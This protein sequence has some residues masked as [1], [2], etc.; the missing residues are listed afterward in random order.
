MRK[1]LKFAFLLALISI[2]QSGS[3]RAEFL[4]A[5]YHGSAILSYALNDD[6][7]SITPLPSSPLPITGGSGSLAVDRSNRF[8]YADTGEGISGYRIK[9]NGSL[10]PLK[11][12]PFKVAGGTLAIDPL[13]RYLYAAAGSPFSTQSNTVSAYRID[14][15]GT[16]KPVPGSPFSTGT[17]PISVSVDPFG[18]FVYVANFVSNNVS[19]FRILENGALMQVLGS[20][21]SSGDAI[22]VLTEPSG[23]FVYVANIF[24]ASISAYHVDPS[25]ALIPLAGSP[26]KT[27]VPWIQ[28]MAIDPVDG[29]LYLATGVRSLDAY[30]F[31][32]NTGEPQFVQQTVTDS[33][34]WIMAVDP[35]SKFVYVAD[36]NR[37]PNLGPDA[38]SGF[39]I[40]PGGVLNPVVSSPVLPPVPNGAFPS[41]I[42]IVRRSG[43]DA[44]K[45]GDPED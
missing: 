20:P 22:T 1:T 34:P 18:R 15:N 29:F 11:G 3:L 2:A 17:Y 26:T 41:S 16:L 35:L 19:V 31:D 37:E 5:S 21:F 4:Y 33:E 9:A 24:E 42:V 45:I 28:T 12:S 32:S 13:N 7:G 38:I 30:H 10:K 36:A 27:L 8:L 14:A 44:T 25:G 39:R 23:R 6:T 40:G 43:H